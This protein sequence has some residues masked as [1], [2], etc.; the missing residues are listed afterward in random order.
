MITKT[1]IINRTAENAGLT[2]VAA[3]AAVDA[4]FEEIALA[5]KEGDSV[6]IAG[7][8]KF[9]V[10]A[11]SERMGTNPQTGKPI[12]IPAKNAAVFKASKTLKEM[13]NRGE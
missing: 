10:R 3:K 1:E 5:L 7:F 11:R 13:L 9:E 8:G 6:A 4:L 12:S 2:K